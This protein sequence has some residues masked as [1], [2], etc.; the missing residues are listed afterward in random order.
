MK[1]FPST[2]TCVLGAGLVCTLACEAT[3]G[4]LPPWGLSRMPHGGC[5]SQSVCGCGGGLCQAPPEPLGCLSASAAGPSLSATGQA[6][7]ATL[8]ILC[9]AIPTLASS[10][11]RP[12]LP[13][14]GLRGSRAR[15]QQGNEAE[16]PSKEHP[17]PPYML[18]HHQCSYGALPP[19]RS[20]FPED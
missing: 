18:A 15:S 4:S 16:D 1:I 9:S 8:T 2:G 14:V 6:A 13:A 17:G 7:Q 19:G 5:I 11:S 3:G 12:S 10:G 20:H